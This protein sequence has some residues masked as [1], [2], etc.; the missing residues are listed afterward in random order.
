MGFEILRFIWFVDLNSVL[1]DQKLDLFGSKAVEWKI[2]MVEEGAHER[3][4]RHNVNLYEQ[5]H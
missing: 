3:Q 1:L 5:Y 4:L 2:A